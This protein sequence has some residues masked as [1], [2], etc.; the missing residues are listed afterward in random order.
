MAGTEMAGT[1]GGAVVGAG[2]RG[3][4]WGFDG[5]V[6]DVVAPLDVDPVVVPSTARG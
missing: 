1:A 2:E 3:A 4:D 6:L 5:E